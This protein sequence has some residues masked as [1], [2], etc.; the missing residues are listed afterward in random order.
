MPLQTPHATRAVLA[1]LLFAVGCALATASGCTDEQPNTPYVPAPMAFHSIGSIAIT[2]MS[3]TPLALDVDARAAKAVM[4]HGDG[5]CID[6]LTVS[7]DTAAGDTITLTFAPRVT[8]GMQLTAATLTR[9]DGKWGLAKGQ[10]WLPLQ[11]LSE[12]EKPGDQP[13]PVAKLLI[14]PRGKI[15]LQ[16][17]DTSSGH[18]IQVDLM[19]ID[20]AKLSFG[21]DTETTRA[22]SPTCKPCATDACK[23][24]Y[25]TFRLRDFQTD[26]PRF[27]LEY[28]LNVYLE[29]PVV[30]ILTQGW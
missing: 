17:L 21:G 25:D 9:A 11:A 24:P 10:G 18:P 1:P 4:T 23:P 7:G 22:A 28:D 14:A 13:I 26:S 12:A 8:F 6:A 27:N 15:E 5:G 2:P 16:R 30:A 19:Q 3:G 20:L 29:E